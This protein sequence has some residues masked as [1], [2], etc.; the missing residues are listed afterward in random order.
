M[1][2]ALLSQITKCPNLF[3]FKANFCEKNPPIRKLQTFCNYGPLGQVRHRV[4]KSVCLF[5]GVAVPAIAE[6]LTSGC[7]RDFWLK[8]IFLIVQFCM[9]NQTALD[10]S[11]V[12]R[13]KLVLLWLLPLH[14]NSN[15]D[16][17]IYIFLVIVN[18]STLIERVSAS[19]MQDLVKKK[20]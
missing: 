20:L 16:I 12:S 3:T 7:S 4:A 10:N 15:G 5:V 8:D 14:S 19:C 17:N 11:G 18:P 13:R 9:F 2:F 6:T 1:Y